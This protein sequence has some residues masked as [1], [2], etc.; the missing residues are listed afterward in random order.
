MMEAVH[1]KLTEPSRTARKA[2]G[3]SARHANSDGLCVKFP[4][5][6]L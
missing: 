6:H 5:V 4:R 3:S 1:A 2:T